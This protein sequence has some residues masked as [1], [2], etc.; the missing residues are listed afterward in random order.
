MIKITV[1]DA[2][3]VFR[4]PTS[5]KSYLIDHVRYMGYV[6]DTV[7]EVPDDYLVDY[8]KQ[9]NPNKPSTN[10]EVYYRSNS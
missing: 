5:R 2:N 1:K 7:E 9:E 3:V 10:R 8:S 6:I 4:A